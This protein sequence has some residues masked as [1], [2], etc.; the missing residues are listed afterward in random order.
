MSNNESVQDSG[1]KE[2][3]GKNHLGLD[4]VRKKVL[5]KNTYTTVKCKDTR[6]ISRDSYS[7]LSKALRVFYNT[8]SGD[9]YDPLFHPKQVVP[10]SKTDKDSELL[11]FD[12][13]KGGCVSE[14]CYLLYNCSKGSL[15]HNE[16]VNYNLSV[17]SQ[18][19]NDF[20][21]IK[22]TLEKRAKNLSLLNKELKSRLHGGFLS[23]DH[24]VRS[25]TDIM[26]RRYP[27]KP[28]VAEK[29][30]R[31]PK[32]LVRD[33]TNLHEVHLR[34]QGPSL[35]DI[36]SG[37]VARQNRTTKVNIVKP[38]NVGNRDSDT[39]VL[40]YLTSVE[41]QSPQE[42]PGDPRSRN[43]RKSRQDEAS[44][45]ESSDESVDGRRTKRFMKSANCKTF[46]GDRSSGRLK[47]KSATQHARQHNSEQPAC[48]TRK[49]W[50]DEDIEAEDPSETPRA[51]L[52]KRDYIGSPISSNFAGRQPA[53]GERRGRT[54]PQYSPT[55][56]KTNVYSPNNGFVRQQKEPDR[57]YITRLYNRNQENGSS[58]RTKSVE[59]KLVCK[60][61]NVKPP[62]E[63]V[64]KWSQ[65]STE[66]DPDS[67]ESNSL[68]FDA[69]ES[70]TRKAISRKPMSGVK[71]GDKSKTRL[72]DKSRVKVE[73]RFSGVQ[74][75]TRK[76]CDIK[77]DKSKTS[78]KCTDKLLKR[79]TF[80]PSYKEKI[81]E[82]R[83]NDGNEMGKSDDEHSAVNES[84][85]EC[86]V[87]PRFE[88][89]RTSGS[90]FGAV[91]KNKQTHHDYVKHQ[92]IKTTGTS[93]KATSL[94]SP[95]ISSYAKRF[96]PRPSFNSQQY[97]NEK[98]I[99][100]ESKFKITPSYLVSLVRKSSSTRNGTYVAESE[101]TVSL[102]EDTR[103]KPLL[104]NNFYE[105]DSRD[106]TY[107]KKLAM[108]NDKMSSSCVC[109]LNKHIFGTEQKADNCYFGCGENYE[110]YNSRTSSPLI[111]CLKNR[112][113]MNDDGYFLKCNSFYK[114]EKPVKCCCNDHLLPNF[115]NTNKRNDSKAI[116]EKFD[117]GG[118]N[119]FQLEMDEINKKL[120]MTLSSHFFKP[121]NYNS[122]ILKILDISQG[123]NNTDMTRS[124]LKNFRADIPVLSALTTV[125]EDAPFVDFQREENHEVEEVSTINEETHSPNVKSAEEKEE[126]KEEVKEE[127]KKEEDKDPPEENKAKEVE[128]KHTDITENEGP[129]V[130]G[131]EWRSSEKDRI[132]S[133]EGK[134]VLLYNKAGFPLT[135][136]KGRCLKNNLGVKM[137]PASDLNDVIAKKLQV[138]DAFNYPPT[139]I[140]FD[141]TKHPCPTQMHDIR[142][143]DKEYNPRILYN[144][145]GYPL[146][147]RDGFLLRDNLGNYLVVL[148]NEGIPMCCSNGEP[149]YMEDGK[150]W[151]TEKDSYDVL[152]RGNEDSTSKHKDKSRS[153]SI[154]SEV[155]KVIYDA[156][157]KSSK[158]GPEVSEKINLEK[159][160]ANYYKTHT[161]SNWSKMKSKSKIIDDRKKRDKRIVSRCKSVCRFRKKSGSEISSDDNQSSSLNSKIG[162]I[163]KNKSINFQKYLTLKK[164][165]MNITSAI[166]KYDSVDE[167]SISSNEDIRI[168][169]EEAKKT[170]RSNSL[171]SLS[172]HLDP[173]TWRRPEENSDTDYTD[174]KIT[175]TKSSNS[176]T[177]NLSNETIKKKHITSNIKSRIN[178]LLDGETKRSTDDSEII[179]KNE[180]KFKTSEHNTSSTT[181]IKESERGAKRGFRPF[182][183]PESDFR[184]R[185]DDGELCAVGPWRIEGKCGE[186]RM[187]SFNDKGIRDGF[188]WDRIG[189]VETRKYF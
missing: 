36:P 128:I 108:M 188:D 84:R 33:V 23:L 163:K 55:S 17:E 143:F 167:R 76:R 101:S 13:G 122:D 113:S 8:L 179:T 135:D 15:P 183:E 129:S 149:I 12:T 67:D 58:A 63:S 22:R 11:N 141:P 155:R 43:C 99:Q 119:N 85:E 148:D 73:S 140:S 120:E 115:D 48:D 162:K 174:S 136:T 125:Q 64:D 116:S 147:D 92:K 26:D 16:N 6:P 126:I 121:E 157:R 25:H 96:N 35:T 1:I 80:L 142:I 14:K 114:D 69:V 170:A 130:R 88:S 145:L 184:Q 47:V 59:R 112:R 133:S 185:R 70:I 104:K 49:R 7:R 42:R 100:K 171:E 132:T 134:P 29:K 10:C 160:T 187:I 60:M 165:F 54:S 137:L 131:M 24:V 156:K 20:K 65:T 82:T 124:K 97:P 146:S 110:K 144:S 169:E 77:S 107:S 109:N 79:S 95:S 5:K 83:T 52:G 180:D 139:T 74:A 123:N 90:S 89:F 44:S 62:D 164:N 93:S 78:S 189:R 53:F 118:K 182:G 68:R 106:L 2:I 172:H 178:H 94:T 56:R 173:T 27:P 37:Y 51:C 166:N 30:T 117:V 176:L 4:V 151:I 111:S 127:G 75:K 34:S 98:V 41:Q 87:S 177:E 9:C 86:R 152:R 61:V 66:S 39:A 138:Y 153:V 175:K 31:K 46:L 72:Q 19:S 159:S 91:K 71:C 50:K 158:L 154:N 186:E 161:R 40:D 105:E 38:V 102:L 150:L 57:R 32:R 18:K 3:R 28:K 168:L 103:A 45:S 181:E 81:N 21:S